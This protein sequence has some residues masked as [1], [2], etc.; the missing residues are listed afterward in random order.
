MGVV[1]HHTILDTRRVAQAVHELVMVVHHLGLHR[2]V[3]LHAPT[4]LGL[5]GV[6][7]QL[8]EL[9]TRRLLR[10][11]HV[12]QRLAR[13]VPLAGGDFHSDGERV[14]AGHG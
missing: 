5:S 6:I 13:V 10:S 11:Q 3:G 4:R 2:G 9:G 7:F 14:Q 8:V 12:L 1:S